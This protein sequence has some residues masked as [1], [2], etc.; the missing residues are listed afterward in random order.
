MAENWAEGS[1]YINKYSSYWKESN[2]KTLIVVQ[3]TKL[4]AYYGVMKVYNPVESRN[5][6]IRPT[7]PVSTKALLN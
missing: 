7:M 6:N 2:P 4:P 5:T 3:R 1:V